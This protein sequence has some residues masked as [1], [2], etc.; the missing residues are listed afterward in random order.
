MRLILIDGIDGLAG[1]I[2][3]ISS[4]SFGAI[5]LIMEQIDIALIAFT[6][7]GALVRIFKVQCFSCQNIYG[8]Y[9]F[10]SCWDDF[11]CFSN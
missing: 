11:I 4:L 5:A 9:R 3:L 7:M 2:G 8:R 6:L 10:F 1:G